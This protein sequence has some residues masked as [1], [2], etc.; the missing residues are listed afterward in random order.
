MRELRNKI[1]A[2]FR[3]AQ[4][5]N[6]AMR[7]CVKYTKHVKETQR[8]ADEEIAKIFLPDQPQDYT[9]PFFRYIAIPSFSALRICA[10]NVRSS[11]VM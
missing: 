10:V 2:G 1:L 5:I 8:R 3:S 4:I 6:D 11:A 9:H 7:G